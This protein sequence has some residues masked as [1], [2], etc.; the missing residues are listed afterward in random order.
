MVQGYREPGSAD[1]GKESLI[2]AF[3]YAIIKPVT[4]MVE[5]LTTPVASAAMLC[6]SLYLR[7]A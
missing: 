1:Q 7:R 3:A 5:L 2:V 6:I 4:V